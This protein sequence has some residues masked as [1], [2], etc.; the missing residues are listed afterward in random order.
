MAALSGERGE[1]T[2]PDRESRSESPRTDWESWRPVLAES[3]AALRDRECLVL[4]ASGVPSRPSVVRPSR[5]RG[6]ISARTRQVHPHLRF[7]RLEDQLRGECIGD[8]R[9]GGLFPFTDDEV[10]VVESLGWHATVPADGPAHY[11]LWW[12]DDVPWAP[13]LPKELLSAAVVRAERTL[14]EAMG[15]TTPEGLETERLDG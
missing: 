5:A 14:R 12:P 10:A 9:I 7:R 8:T 4:T 13:Y 1:L 11:Q 2:V 6:L 15:L 3:L